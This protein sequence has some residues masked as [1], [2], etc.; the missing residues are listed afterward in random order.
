ML[1]SKKDKVKGKP[2][3]GKDKAK[4]LLARKTKK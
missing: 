2:S 1:V 4:C 3:K